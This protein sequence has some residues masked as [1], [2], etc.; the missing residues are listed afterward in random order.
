MNKSSFLVYIQRY[1][2]LFFICIFYNIN[3]AHASQT[4]LATIYTSLAITYS[5]ITHDTF[6]LYKK[7]SCESYA[8]DCSLPNTV[9]DIDTKV[10]PQTL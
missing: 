5:G 2:C 9:E 8:Q 1:L 7:Q 6:A 4:P 10:L 3:T